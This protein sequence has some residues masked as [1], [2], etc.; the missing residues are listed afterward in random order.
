VYRSRYVPP[1]IKL[2]GQVLVAHGQFDAH[3]L[4]RTA[5][6]FVRKTQNQ[7]D[8]PLPHVAERKLF[9]DSNRAAQTGTDHR[10][11]LQPHLGMLAAEILEILAGDK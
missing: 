11:H 3:S 2:R 1:A 4:L 9:D 10:D 5:S 7:G 8:Q 6:A